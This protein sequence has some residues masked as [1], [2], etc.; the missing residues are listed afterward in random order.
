MKKI[1]EII[2]EIEDRRESIIR[3]AKNSYT[4][5][6]KSRGSLDNYVVLELL[7]SKYKRREG[8]PGNYKYF[9]DD[10]SSSSKEAKV[11]KPTDKANIGKEKSDPLT[12][13]SEKARHHKSKAEEA[14]KKEDYETAGVH[15]ELAGHHAD[16]ANKHADKKLKAADQKVKKPEEGITNAGKKLA[17]ENRA[18][19]DKEQEKGNLPKTVKNRS[20]EKW[21]M[22]DYKKI[23]QE[24][25]KKLKDARENTQLMIQ[26][27]KD[28]FEGERRNAADSSIEKLHEKEEVKKSGIIVGDSLIKSDFDDMIF[29][30]LSEGKK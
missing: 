1:S 10:E 17:A 25:A 16:E 26:A 23:S 28:S 30:H 27:D 4:D 13:H 3:D 12:F 2:K 19:K 20:H 15:L 9:Y 6:K 14:L 11:K 29:E 21:K 18:K 5:L 7:K 8:T 22:P 24:R